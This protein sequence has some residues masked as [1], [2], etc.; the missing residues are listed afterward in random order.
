MAI[1]KEQLFLD[2][3]ISY[4]VIRYQ[5]E[6]DFVAV[7]NGLTLGT[8]AFTNY[9][10][11]GGIGPTFWTVDVNSPSNKFMGTDQRYIP[12]DFVFNGPAI[13]KQET[14]LTLEELELTAVPGIYLIDQGVVLT[15]AVL[16]YKNEKTAANVRAVVATNSN[17][18]IASDEITIDPSVSMVTIDSI[19]ISGGLTVVE[20]R[21]AQGEW[22]HDGTY[23]HDGTLTY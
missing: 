21:F 5:N 23:L 6:P 19:T 15:G 14:P 17:Y 10:K 1:S 8:I 22:I 16:V 9:Q 2:R 4:N 7:L 3:F 11:F 18:A 13:L 12:A 20:S